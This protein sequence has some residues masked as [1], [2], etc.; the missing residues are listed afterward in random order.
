[1]VIHHLGLKLQETWFINNYTV[2]ISEMQKHTKQEP[3]VLAI[4][5]C[6][7]TLDNDF[8]GWQKRRI[9]YT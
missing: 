5:L 9:S 6:G 1:M 4:W 8:V 3:N 7:C 2:H